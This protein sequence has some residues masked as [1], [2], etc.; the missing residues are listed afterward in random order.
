MGLGGRRTFTF[1]GGL[2]LRWVH[3]AL[4]KITDMTGAKFRFCASRGLALDVTRHGEVH[5]SVSRWARTRAN[6]SSGN[7]V[8]VREVCERGSPESSGGDITPQATVPSLMTVR[9]EINHPPG[10]PVPSPGIQ[11]RCVPLAVVL[12]MAA[13]IVRSR[14]DERWRGRGVGCKLWRCAVLRGSRSP[15]RWSA[16]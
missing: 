8:T 12:E 2:G 15:G 10:A 6:A 4:L 1:L 14:Y 3:R 7:G 11:K 9:I 13:G 16:G 5:S